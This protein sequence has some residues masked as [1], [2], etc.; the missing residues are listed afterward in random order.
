MLGAQVQSDLAFD[1]IPLDTHTPWGLDAFRTGLTDCS[2]DLRTLRKRQLPLL[3]LRANP[4]LSTTLSETLSALQDRCD[5]AAITEC[6]RPCSD[7][8]TQDTLQQ[9]VW[10]PSS[11]GAWLN[12]NATVLQTIHTW[13]TLVLPA[14][15]ILVPILAIVLPFLLL[16]LTQGASAPSASVYARNVFASIKQQLSIPA[17]LKPR[18]AT[19]RIGQTL[20]LL[21][22]L[23]SVVMFLSGIW[24]QM[25]AAQHLRRVYADLCTRGDS[26]ASLYSACAKCVDALRSV[27]PK[28]QRA[29]SA[30]IDAGEHA[31][32]AAA[33]LAAGGGIAAYGTAWN[34]PAAIEGLRNWIGH[35]DVLVTIARSGGICIPRHVACGGGLRIEGVTHPSLQRSVPNTVSLPAHAI[36][37]GPNRGGKSTFCRAVTLAIVTAQSWGFA[38]ASA[39]TLTPFAHIVTALEGAGRLGTYSTFEAEI[40]FANRVLALPA[41]PRAPVYIC[42]DEI[43]H[44]TNA[45]D[46]VEASRIF[47]D[48]LYT[49]RDGA[50]VSIISTHYRELP[51]HYGAAG[52]DGAPPPVQCLQA[53]ARMRDDDTVD[54]TYTVSEGVSSVSSV[55]ELLRERGLLRPHPVNTGA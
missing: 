49:L 4:S 18:H 27:S 43:F 13:K 33:P 28:H 10:N 20:E 15:A 26:C 54:Y 2:A 40:A 32:D 31:L 39:M 25:S 46:G 22:V 55:R 53:V 35:L 52:A 50:C 48:R 21:F 1:S 45:R 19:D 11:Y 6:S 23:A 51:E 36:L 8:R 30:L 9:I 12:Q 7:P 41:T 42:M 16:R 5:T 47:L 17:F 37:T 44:S 14:S 3:A 24:S 29:F 38:W 34:A